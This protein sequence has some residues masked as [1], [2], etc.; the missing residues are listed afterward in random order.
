ML[1]VSRDA[2]VRQVRDAFRA[3]LIGGAHPDMGGDPERFQSL[4]LAYDSASAAASQATAA[5]PPEGRAQASSP[6]VAAPM[7]EAPSRPKTIE[8]LFKLRS[9]QRQRFADS[10][11]LRRSAFADREAGKE[12]LRKKRAQA[13]DRQLRQEML[14][15]LQLRALRDAPTPEAREAWKRELEGE[16]LLS[17][18]RGS[19]VNVFASTLDDVRRKLKK[20]G[21]GGLRQGVGKRSRSGDASVVGSRMVRGAAGTVRVPVYMAPD[22]S[23]YYTSPLTS[24]RIALGR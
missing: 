3:A 16:R 2:T 7:P 20:E 23:R 14:R 18:K 6:A 9:E 8:D 21:V 22:G 17:E 24:K 11:Q 5:V 10:G 15:A 1:G 4:K 19:G 13:E 12:R